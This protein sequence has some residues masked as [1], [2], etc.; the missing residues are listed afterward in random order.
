MSDQPELG[1]PEAIRRFLERL[2]DPRNRRW[3]CRADSPEAFAEWQATARPALRALIGLDRIRAQAGAHTPTVVRG[4]CEPMDGYTRQSCMIETEPDVSIPFWLLRP[5]RRGPCPL[6]VTP[7]GHG[8][9]D[10]DLYAGIARNASQARRLAEEDADVA[11]QAV[12][13]GFVAIA[14]ATRGLADGGIADVFDR[15]GG[16]DCTSHAIQ[17]MLAGRTSVG[18]RVWDME[19]ILDWACTLDEVDARAV[20]MLGNSGGG[21]L[22]LFAAACDTRIGVAVSSCAY[23]SFVGLN[24]KIQHHHCNAVPGMT[25]F[26]ES[27]DVAALIA[28]RFFLA[29][30]GAGDTLKATDEVDRAV[31]ELRAIHERAGIPCRFEQRYGQGGHRFYAD[32][33]WPFVTAAIR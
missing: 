14:P 15:F 19:R 22:T 16:S 5:A 6:A 30:H 29:V 24:G 2:H 4:A 10:R 3:A 13:R 12:R 21:V 20:A 23:S 26:G 9:T 8:R 28:P 17:V 7:H 11:V 1:H 25:V 32:L 31:R 27:W 33:M 18:E